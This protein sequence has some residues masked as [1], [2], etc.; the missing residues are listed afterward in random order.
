MLFG[1][2]PLNPQFA[3]TGCNS[4]RDV[5]LL[6]KS[7]PRIDEGRGIACEGSGRSRRKAAADGNPEQEGNPA[8]ETRRVSYSDA[9]RKD[10][11]GERFP[12]EE[13][14]CPFRGAGRPGSNGGESHRNSG[15]GGTDEVLRRL[16]GRSALAAGKRKQSRVK[17]S[18]MERRNAVCPVGSWTTSPWVIP[19][20]DGETDLPGGESQP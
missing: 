16:G 7:A 18:R 5:G 15:P 17:R 9:V 8:G 1:V 19:G 11:V 4:D 2:E 13:G 20:R 14:Y 6:R 10:G 12:P 3:L